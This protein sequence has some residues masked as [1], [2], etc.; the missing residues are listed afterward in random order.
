MLYEPL[1]IGR[2]CRKCNVW[3]PYAELKKHKHQPDGVEKMCSA[4][5]R[6]QASNYFTEHH[7][8]VLNNLKSV[9]AQDPDKVKARNKR[10]RDKNKTKILLKIK[11]W[12]KENSQKVRRYKRDSQRKHIAKHREQKRIAENERRARKIG[13]PNNFTVNEWQD[14]LTYWH[15]CCAICDRP[16]GLWHTIAADHW[17]PLSSDQCPGTIASNMLPLC[18]SLKDGEG[19]CNNSKFN[20]DPIEWLTQKL[21]PRKAKQKLAEIETYFAS[22]KA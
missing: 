7:D 14:C 15:G 22:L 1:P 16:A 12:Q 18:H 4:C 17:I 3:K 8:A 5:N 10:S 21:G 11:Q 19:G 2:I 9:Y 13:L 20:R 6:K